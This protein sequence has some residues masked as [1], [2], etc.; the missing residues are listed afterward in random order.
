MRAGRAFQIV[1]AMLVS[2]SPLLAQTDP[3]LHRSVAVNVFDNHGEMVTGLTAKN[4]QGSLRRQPVKILSVTQG[5]AARVVIVLDA[6]G[7]MLS[8]KSEWEFSI[9]SAKQLSNAFSPGVPLGL[10]V[11]SARV[12]KTISLTNDR[13]AVMSELDS[14]K[15]GR[16]AILKGLRKTALGR[17]G[18]S[19]VTLRSAAE[20]G[21][22]L[23]GLGR[24]GQCEPC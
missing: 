1:T 6:S 14:L 11:F 4:F 22:A 19:P 18:R 23:C 17:N 8:N 3:C 7:S 16:R 12:E 24:N 9:E 20:W 21:H 2:A 5:S 10:I 13:Q 15:T